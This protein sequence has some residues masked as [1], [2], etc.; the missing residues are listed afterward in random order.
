MTTACGGTLCLIDLPQDMP[1]F[2]RFIS[3]WFFRDALGRSLVVDPGPMS[4]IPLLNKEL[5]GLADGVD[6]IL[7]THIHLDHAGGIGEFCKSWPGATVIAHPRA[8]RHLREPKKLWSASV[9]TLGDVA[10]AY[11]E[12]APLSSDVPLAEGD[13]AGL[14]EVLPT[15]GHAPHHISLRA[16]SSDG[17]RLLF[18]GEAA[19]MA[20]PTLDDKLW[21]R[22]ATPPRY[23]HKAAI[24]SM[25]L[26]LR[27]IEGG[28][29]LC[30]AHWGSA[31]D[32]R[33]RIELAREQY[34][35]WLETIKAMS[36]RPIDGIVERL[37]ASDP[38]LQ[39]ELEP[40]LMER[41]RA[42][43]VN[44]VRGFL[45]FISEADKRS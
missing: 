38:L 8:F 34:G 17:Q 13:G 1:G 24:N 26:L 21:L 30:Y 31:E 18:A 44:S 12:P 37:L 41:E 5:S 28:E 20:V 35:R 42:F 39:A 14:I 9:K 19:G 23:D 25:D 27:V 33:G 4:T 10:L 36:D 32:A 11:G 3:C 40:D 6:L 2:R 43:I 29:L 15:P 45:G 22:P 16:P 7:L